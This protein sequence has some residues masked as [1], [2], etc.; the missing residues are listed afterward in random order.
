MELPLTDA[1]DT[2]LAVGFE[3]NTVKQ[4]VQVSVVLGAGGVVDWPVTSMS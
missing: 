3:A 2:A 4:A 1:G